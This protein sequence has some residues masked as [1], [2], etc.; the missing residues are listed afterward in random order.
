V[1]DLYE[2]LM[3]AY[4]DLKTEIKNRNK[5]LFERWKAGGFIIDEDIISGYPNLQ[6][7]LEELGE[8][9]DEETEDFEEEED[10]N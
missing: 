2:E 9:D 6:K 1:K 8:F 3:S 4:Y 5:Y 7:V 10:E